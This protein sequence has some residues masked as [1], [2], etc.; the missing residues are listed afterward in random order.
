MNIGIEIPKDY[1]TQKGACL[2]VT[3]SG[4]SYGIANIMDEFARLDVP[5]VLLDVMGAHVGIAKHW[6][7]VYLYGGTEGNDL[8]F[9]EGESFARVI[10][11]DNQSIVI[12]VS[13]FSDEEMQT[14]C[15]DLLHELFRLHM[16][17]KTPRHIFVE[18]A[19]VFFP[20]THFD[21]SRHSLLAGNKVMKRGRSVGLGMTLISQRPQDVNKKT[22]SQA[23]CTFILHMEGVQ[24]LAVVEKILR[25]HDK[26]KRIELLSK[27]EKFQQ[28][29]CLL[30]SPAW[31]G[32]VETFKFKERISK[33]YGDTPKLEDVD[34]GVSTAQLNKLLSIEEEP[35]K[36]EPDK[37][38]LGK[39][40]GIILACAILIIVAKIMW[41]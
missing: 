27:I 18:E 39:P 40:I 5:F 7:N 12:D 16:V 8:D 21:N 3:G 30:Y 9:R 13:H 28:G 11:R 17:T 4:K 20:Q 41:N 35:K 1:V 23:Q 33:H 32:K 22:L 24:E 38:P 29:Q 19:E 37:E 14:F 26:D 36:K 31:L 10:V 2:G 34:K 15:G 6:D 25:S